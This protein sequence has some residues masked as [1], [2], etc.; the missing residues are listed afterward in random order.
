MNEEL[1]VEDNKSYEKF[2]KEQAIIMSQAKEPVKPLP[3]KEELEKIK[4]E[5]EKKC[6]NTIVGG[7]LIFFIII[8]FPIS[9]PTIVCVAILCPD[10]ISD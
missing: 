8:T 1:V 7:I 9:I 3:T 5:Q 4:R 10:L 2:R 6:K